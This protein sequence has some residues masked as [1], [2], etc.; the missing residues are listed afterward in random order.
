LFVADSVDRRIL[1]FTA[2]DTPLLK[3][4]ISNSASLVTGPLA[5][6]TLV[7]ITGTSFADSSASAPDDSIQPLPTKLGNV[8]VL[9]DGLAL[10]LLSV[11]P[12]QIRAQIPY[13]LGDRSSASM[14]VRTEHNDGR[15]TTTSAIAVKIVAANPG[16]FAFG[17][18]EPRSGLVLHAKIDSDGQSGVPVTVE[19]PARPGETLIVWAAGLGAVK[20]GHSTARAR[21]GVPYTGSDARV[22]TPVDALVQGRSAD[23]VSAVLPRGSIGIYEV[24]VVLP[25]DLPNNAKAQLLIA[26][27]G[28]VSNRITVPVESAA[29]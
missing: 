22:A 10:A 21:M 24:R 28:Y 9:F 23:V 25:A 11:S 5:P 4:A 6:G 13:E 15:I 17:G 7:T 26:Q 29:R 8:E 14:Y 19:N 2:A 20:E 12:T 1:V 16:L 27:N 3:N 18:A